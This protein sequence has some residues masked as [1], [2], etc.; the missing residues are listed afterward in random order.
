MLV[1]LA[2]YR[3]YVGLVLVLTFLQTMSTLY[4]PQLMSHIVDHG[5]VL[6]REH[7]ILHMG[8]WM[9]AITILGGMAAVGAS[10]FAAH[11]SSGFGQRLRSR[12][13]RHVE[14]FGLAE[15]NQIGTSSL[16]VRT[17]NDV[18]QVQQLVNMMLRMMVIAPLTAIG[19][20]AMAIHTS[21]HLSESLIIIIPLLGL[22]IAAVLGRGLGLFRVLQSKVDRLNR[23][24]REN[25]IGVRVVRAFHRESLERRRFFD[26]NTDLTDTSVRVFQLMA[27]MMPVVTLIMNLATVAVF[28]WGS[29]Q[30][31]PRGLEVGSLM[32][33]VQYIM[34]IMFSVMML[35]M[36]A[37][38][39][40][41]GE[42]SAQR[43]E[44]VLQIRLAITDSTE[45]PL[46]PLPRDWAELSFRHVSFAYPGAEAPALED[47]SFTAHLGQTVAIIGGT[48]SGKSTLINLVV[49]FY[50]PTAGTITLDGV[51]IRTLPLETLRQSLGLVPQKAVLF[52]GSVVENI[53][54]GNPEASEDEIFAALKTAQAWEFVSGLEGSLHH[55]L[56]QG[57]ANLSGGQRQRLAIAR[58]IV[59]HPNI[60]LFDDSFSALD[61]KTDALLRRS[62]KEQTQD[63][64]VLLV[65]QRI[66]TIVDADLIL[67][68]DD[69]KLVGQ[70][71]HRD[72][73]Q[74]CAVYR[75]IA[76]SQLS[77]EE[78]A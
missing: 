74:N 9:L 67:V 24:V 37:F 65:A 63:A 33:F 39:I 78:I 76:E 68:L 57:G 12:I 40:P 28:W 64:I 8:L 73:L 49:R 56:D 5:I 51:D 4:L 30:I 43:I 21:P 29:L 58:A 27:L 34:Q 54:Y 70:G 13:F 42:A 11:A 47:I 61:Y 52:S 36:M 3:T 53:R 14:A 46:T 19:G 26:A 48:G 71:R 20:I 25:L 15:F 10:Y 77:P 22:A 60:Y 45:T 23:V 75:E 7:Y 38:M 1:F 72:L 32:A 17:T 18:M 35:S 50:D 66:A 31:A 44:E 69:G 41:R 2:P 55:L 62:L 6:G 16:I 59:R